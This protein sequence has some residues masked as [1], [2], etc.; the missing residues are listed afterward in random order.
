MNSQQSSHPDGHNTPGINTPS[1]VGRFGSSYAGFT[2]FIYK[3][4][5]RTGVQGR[6]ISRQ[7]NNSSQ[8]YVF[9][10]G[11][12]AENG[13]V[14]F[15]FYC[16]SPSIF[17]DRREQLKQT[18]DSRLIDQLGKQVKWKHFEQ[19]RVPTDVSSLLARNMAQDKKR[20]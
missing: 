7:L 20:L 2:G 5:W 4:T 3:S 1:F 15:G 6:C 8:T 17:W 14:A 18:A 9:L 19:I 16:G 12:S 13:F 11:R 10:Y